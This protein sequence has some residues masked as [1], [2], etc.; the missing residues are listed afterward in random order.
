MSG[1]GSA[2]IKQALPEWV[3]RSKQAAQPQRKP[4]QEPEFEREEIA[5]EGA[6]FKADESLEAILQE[7]KERGIGRK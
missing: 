4:R 7:L 2:S 5:G 6:H 3:E 1:D